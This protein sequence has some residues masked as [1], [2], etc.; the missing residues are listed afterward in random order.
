MRI[1][2]ASLLS[3]LC[4]S[5]GA[6]GAPEATELQAS[7]ATVDALGV[8]TYQRCAGATFVAHPGVGFRS[9]HNRRIAQVTPR[10]VVSDVLGLPDAELPVSAHFAY[11][12][13]SRDLRN[14]DINLF[15]HACDG[16]QAAG[17]AVTDNDG[18]IKV[19]LRPPRLDIGEYDLI[20]EVVGD[21][22]VARAT[23]RVLPAETH[24]VVFDVDGTL[25]ANNH[26]LLRLLLPG[27]HP[28]HAY[29]A[30][31]QLTQA[32]HAKGY[33]PMYLVGRLPQLITLT[34]NWLRELF[35]APGHVQLPTTNREALP[36]ERF[37]GEY[38]RRTLQHWHD[39][40][41]RIDYAYG[42]E[43]T[44]LY[45]YHA[46]G[47]PDTHIFV[48]GT[49]VV[50]NEAETVVHGYT[51]H[52]QRILALPSVEQPFRWETTAPAN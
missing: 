30:A 5:L 26:E 41:Y 25:T 8:P 37:V 2:L 36:T 24:L 51:E 1:L 52:V 45:A 49:K 11:G 18:R 4:G 10:H 50:H 28:P 47:I 16:W 14:E 7:A 9:E 42:N 29:P 20:E 22:S 32:W 17:T 3:L 46:V 38:K 13:R 40:G 35:F 21:G 15:V 23:L 44:D 33:V 48:A 31:A 27:H 6:C 19:A 12:V 43:D 39:L 34:R